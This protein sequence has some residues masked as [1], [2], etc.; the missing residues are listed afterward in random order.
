MK[1]REQRIKKKQKRMKKRKKGML[2]SHHLKQ[3]SR[4]IIVYR[5]LSKTFE[6][7]YKPYMW[8]AI[9][10]KATYECNDYKSLLYC[11]ALTLNFV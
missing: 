9:Y 6:E 4:Y 2:H 8:L 3:D 11:M 10:S 1:K 5:P 7:C